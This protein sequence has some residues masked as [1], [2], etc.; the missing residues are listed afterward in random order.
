MGN[1]VML[2]CVKPLWNSLDLVRNYVLEREEGR[3]PK[4]A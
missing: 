2:D 1:R 4:A 3:T